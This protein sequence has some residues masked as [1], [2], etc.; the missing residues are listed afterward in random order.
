[1]M[2]PGEAG[3]PAGRPP[4]EHGALAPSADELREAR[5]TEFLDGE[6]S[7]DE[8]DALFDQDDDL[9]NALDEARAGRD[10]LA[11]LDRPAVPHNF[12][13]KVQRRLRRRTAGRMG[14][15]AA[16]QP[17]GWK[18]SVE[19]FVVIAVVVMAGCWYILEAGRY[20]QGERLVDDA[21]AAREVP[22]EPPRE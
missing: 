6:I 2:S 3:G 12:L 4:V 16:T 17:F 8:L 13:R 21:P 5:L 15:P 20:T 18:L 7:A 9:R 14:H 11:T 19:V 22:A 10:L 1:M